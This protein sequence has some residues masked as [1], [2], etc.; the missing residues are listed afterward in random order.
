AWIDVPSPFRAEQL[1]VRIATQISTRYRQRERTLPALVRLMGE[2]YATRPGNYLAFFS[3]HDYLQQAAA[4]FMATYPD[5]PCRLQ[6]RGMDEAGQAAFLDGFVA[7]GQGIGFA[8]LGGS[9]AEGVDLP[10]DRLIGAFVA[11]LGLPQI[12]PVNEQLRE[13]LERMFG[14]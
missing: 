3:S 6:P 14:R 7:G 8:V 1:D 9:F 10:G 5:I 13:R 12:N 4:Q 2:Q 11:T